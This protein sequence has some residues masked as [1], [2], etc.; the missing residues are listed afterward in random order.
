M[1]TAPTP[2]ASLLPRPVRVGLG[3]LAGVGATGTSAGL[4]YLVN[5]I[6]VDVPLIDLGGL[7]LIVPLVVIP[8]IAGAAIRGAATVLATIGAGAAV[9]VAAGFA[10]D[11]CG[12]ATIW[13]AMGL[14]IVG[15]F[16][17]PLIAG[18]A[19]FLGTLPGLRD[20]FERHRVRWAWGL[21][22][23]GA[24]GAVGWAAFL[25]LVPSCP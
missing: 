4:G 2:Q 7:I 19:A 22:A 20:P 3:L 9:T 25:S 13:V 16:F 14:L 8:F 18:C 17:V 24:V 6:D 1:T 10:I 21:A 11:N 15:F 12:E 5:Q 23:S